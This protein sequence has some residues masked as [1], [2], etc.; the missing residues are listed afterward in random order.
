MN[1]VKKNTVVFVKNKMKI[2]ID[3]NKYF[4]SKLEINIRNIQ[5]NIA[6]M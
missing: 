5:G 3:T 2:K 4:F 1:I 6:A